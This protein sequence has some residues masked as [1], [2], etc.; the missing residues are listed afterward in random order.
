MY[1][2]KL[3]L[4]YIDVEVYSLTMHPFWKFSWSLMYS[5]SMLSY[6]YV[7]FIV[8][9]VFICHCSRCLVCDCFYVALWRNSNP[10]VPLVQMSRF[11]LVI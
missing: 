5:V 10:R 3:S 1:A 7:R 4:K 9:E 2:P 11:L 8:P 6:H